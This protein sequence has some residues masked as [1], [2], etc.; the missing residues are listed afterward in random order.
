MILPKSYI[1]LCNFLYDE[2]NFKNILIVN[3]N[4]TGEFF[5]DLF[6]DKKTTRLMYQHFN[7]NPFISQL[8]RLYN[9]GK[10]YDL[11]C[12]DPFHEYKESKSNFELLSLLL[13]DDGILISHDCSPP[14][15]DSASP[16][17]KVGEWCGVTYAAFIE[18]AYKNPE[19]YYS[20][21]DNDY[22]LGIISKKEMIL[23][24]KIINNEKQKEFL[25]YFS[26]GM[27]NEAYDYFKNNSEELINLMK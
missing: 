4:V 8:K 14:N 17:Y 15:L 22:G 18:F 16:I 7:Y 5:N 9:M 6:I 1:E 24:K 19:Y 10:R 2:Y 25:D 13:T 27:Y 21:I 12:L 26:S 23:V 3:T 20:I 11:I